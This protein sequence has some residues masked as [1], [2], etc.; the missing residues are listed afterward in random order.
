MDRKENRC[1]QE[2]SGGEGIVPGGRG[3]SPAKM[4]KLCA[5]WGWL[6]LWMDQMPQHCTPVNGSHGKWY[7]VLISPQ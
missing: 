7:V 3:L 1:Y 4:P 2:L 5:R 6:A